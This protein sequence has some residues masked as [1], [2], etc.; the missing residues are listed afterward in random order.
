MTAAPGNE[1]QTEL[2]TAWLGSGRTEAEGKASNKR[3]LGPPWLAT[4]ARL[5]T[6]MRPLV[7]CWTDVGLSTTGQEGSATRFCVKVHSREQPLRRAGACGRLD[8]A[9]GYNQGDHSKKQLLNDTEEKKSCIRSHGDT[10]RNTKPL[11]DSAPE[12]S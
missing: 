9:C 7:L 5:T 8:W 2:G 10:Q 1:Q 4:D 6:S 12:K 11:L 3:V